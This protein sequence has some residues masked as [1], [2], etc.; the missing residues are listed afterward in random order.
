MGRTSEAVVEAVSDSPANQDAQQGAMLAWVEAVAPFGIFTT[1]TALKVRSW[2][3]WLVAESGLPAAA[4]VGRELTDVFPDLRERRLDENFHRALQGE[5]S[6]LSTALHRYLLP[7]NPAVPTREGEPM[8]Q[9]ARIAPLLFEGRIVGTIATVEDVTQR[10]RQAFILRRQQEH[11]R[12]F[13]ASLALLLS[14]ETPL[15]ALADLFPTVAIPLKLD[16]YFNYLVTPDGSELRLQ[17]A[18]G[19]TPDVRKAMATLKVGE[20]L[21][22]SI[23]SRQTP[24]MVAQVQDSP[25]P[26]MATMRQLGLRVFAGF[27]LLVGDRLVGTLSFGSYERDSLADDEV[28]LLRKVAVNLALAID[29]E[30]RERA[31]SQARKTL[32]EHAGNLEA[33][34]AE[35]TVRLHETIEQLESFSYTVAH[36]LRAPI[37]SLK[38]FSE[39]LLQDYAREIPAG[40]QDLLRRLH[41]AGNRLDALTRDLLQFSRI[42][43]QDVTLGPVD[44]SELVRE[45]VMLMPALQKGVLTIAQPLGWVWAQST[46]LQQ[47]LSNL[48]DNAVKFAGAGV[49][50]RIV[51]RSERVGNQAEVERRESGG[52]FNSP[53]SHPVIAISNS[54]RLRI[55]VEDNGIG[56]APHSHQKIFGIFERVSGLDHVEGT[57]I[58]LAI[59][60]RAMQ[61]MG[62]T[63]GVESAVGAG[64]RF[65]LEL[66]AAPAPG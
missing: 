17:A 1:D 63:C 16:V 58:G 25:D 62:G 23:A 14:S 37:R 13:S 55:W 65:W 44:T 11:D 45:I 42:A 57:G 46:L 30:L 54:P 52:P 21:L 56:I 12:I 36:D 10:E 40:G 31:L 29:R 49:T 3:Q 32:A 47:C 39:I 38:S 22:G 18:G 50:P 48:F 34:V 53:V 26:E 66:A 33:K 28:D 51:V 27:P 35:R 41:R 6:V 7:L 61:Q 5:I 43:R 4:V 8:L 9:T 19:V 64:S 60:A 59:V 24:R 2:N 15:R 20:G